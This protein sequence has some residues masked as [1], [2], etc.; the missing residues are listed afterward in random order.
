[1][2]N[3]TTAQKKAFADLAA[4]YDQRVLQILKKGND[5]EIILEAVADALA[6]EA[7][8]KR[9]LAGLAMITPTTW[10]RTWTLTRTL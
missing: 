2:N 9:L 5:E 8:R 1:M 4:K 3:V 7:F 10:A 6:L